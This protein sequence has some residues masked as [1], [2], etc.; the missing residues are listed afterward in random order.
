MCELFCVYVY[1]Y[2]SFCF[3]LAVSVSVPPAGTRQRCGA[4][5]IVRPKFRLL[6]FIANVSSAGRLKTLARFSPLPRGMTDDEL[7]RWVR[8]GRGGLKKT[9]PTL[10]AA[11]A[12]AYTCCH[13]R[14][15]VN[16]LREEGAFRV[17]SV[18]R[19][20]SAQKPNNTFHREHSRKRIDNPRTEVNFLARRNNV[21]QRFSLISVRYS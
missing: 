12:A 5:D 16:S 6:L 18:S 21:R 11:A 7:A 14:H 9:G 13:I 3:R 8:G 2:C 1:I 10:T 20:S 4:K 17:A 15:T 19:P